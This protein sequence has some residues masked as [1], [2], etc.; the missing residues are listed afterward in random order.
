MHQVRQGACGA[1]PPPV[2]AVR[3]ETSRGRPGAHEAARAEGKLYGGRDPDAKR[4]SARAGSR[5]RDTARRDAGLCPRCGRRPPVEGGATCGPCREVR[6]VVERERYAAR[7]AA[8]LCVRCGGTV[9][10]GDARCGPCAV[11]EEERR[12]P[13]RKNAAARRRYAERRAAGRCTDCGEPSQGASRCEPC[14]R[15]SYER[16][17]HFR[18]MPLWPPSFALF[19]RETDECLAT[20][21]DEMEA[22]AWLAFEKLDRNAVEIVADRSPLATLAAWE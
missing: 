18:G 7:R 19:L 16:S 13:E 4:R 17:D 12:S 20:F 2:R 11:L 15:R 9:L 3:R 22:V 6:Q 8:G 21:D 1:G 5:K 14:A 10:D